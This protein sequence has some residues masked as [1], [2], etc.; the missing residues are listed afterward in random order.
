[1]IADQTISL[2]LRADGFEVVGQKLDAV[3]GRIDSLARH[4]QSM[5]HLGAAF[6]A[7][8][9]AATM[10]GTHF[11]GLIDTADNINDLS[12]KIGIS[13]R[14]LGAWQ[15][16]AEQSGASL[17]TIGKSIKTLAPT[18][19]EFG[20]E[21]AALGVST[22]DP[23]QA[24]IDLADIISAMPDGFEKNALAVK[25]FGKA[26]ADLIPLLNLG[27]AGLA[28]ARVKAE[29]Y[30]AAL[31]KLAPQADAFNDALKEFDLLVKGQ[32]M[33][34]LTD[35][36]KGATG[37]ISFF[38][39][40]T[41][42]V[43]GFR[44]AMDFLAKLELP[45]ILVQINLLAGGFEKLAAMKQS[46]DAY[47]KDRQGLALF[48]GLPSPV[49]EKAAVGAHPAG[50]SPDQELEL[51]AKNEKVLAAQR[52]KNLL[53]I[54]PKAAKAGK[55]SGKDSQEAIDAQW[56]RELNSEYTRAQSETKR[57]QEAA[58]RAAEH[59]AEA[60]Q[61]LRERYL[62]MGDP[63][64]RYN[65]QLIEIEQ[66]RLR[67]VLSAEEAA[68]ATAKVNEQMEEAK[69]KLVDL[70]DKGDDEFA[71][72]TRAV[73]G[74]GRQFTDTLA[75]MAMGGKATFTDL[76]DS[77]IRD[78]MR[79]QIQK[80]ITDPLIKAG[81]SLLDGAVKGGGGLG[82][83]FGNLFGGGS[84]LGGSPYTGGINAVNGL[85]IGWSF[86]NGGIMSASGAL[87]LNKYA[88]GG[89][90]TS[91]QL[92]VFGEGSM[93]E[94][95]VPL[96]DGRSIPVQMRGGGGG[97][98]ISMPVTIDARG[99]SAEVVPLIQQSMQQVLAQVRRE[100]PALV[101]RQQLRNGA[102]PFRA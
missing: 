72:L 56:W 81:T 98:S 12:Q 22:N 74:W 100:V 34:L 20:N 10:V 44:R 9:G 25:L 19:Q 59:E 30:A 35:Q 54:G 40:A 68:A 8:G 94:A 17:E 99:A 15:L 28:E 93:N 96:P 63:L 65:D 85:D 61:H 14:D 43:E 16:A 31:E 23:N 2:K 84:A 5:G 82:G 66:L 3:T 92:A 7:L 70:A 50:L 55:S 101:Q 47:W 37:L 90:A 33:G 27:S 88:G 71:R 51:G 73:E 18:M 53:G 41:S 21:F 11:K 32:S 97:V 102:T 1:M 69:N 78:L 57:V 75:D 46:F 48:T 38:T 77:I 67:D 60:M 45:A 95:F 58:A 86:A 91:P 62:E 36:I 49:A 87:P 24:L 39:D 64:K 89:I 83:L 4:A 26:G 13:V 79:I 29:K 6:T 80:N 42:G 76:A 52:L